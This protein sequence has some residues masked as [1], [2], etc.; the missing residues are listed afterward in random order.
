MID[1]AILLVEDNPL[2]MELAG[3]ILRQA[4]LT[5][6]Q[7]ATAQEGLRLAVESRPALVL[8][9]IQLPDLD[10]LEAVRRLRADPRTASIP[11]VALTAQAMKG[12]QAAALAAGC[13]GYITKPIN[14]RSFVRDVLAHLDAPSGRGNAA[15]P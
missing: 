1:G 2:N 13:N 15:L 12:D 5:V 4:G 14:T 9:D 11:V 3:E 7:A 6:L 10:G 8:L